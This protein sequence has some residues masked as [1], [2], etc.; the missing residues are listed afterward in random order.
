MS[1]DVYTLK[2]KST[3]DIWKEEIANA[4]EQ[5]ALERIVNLHEC[6]DGIYEMIMCDMS[7]DYESG[8]LDDWSLKLIPFE[9]SS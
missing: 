1:T 7:H 8:Y 4:G 3:F 5:D 6:A 2:R 9:E